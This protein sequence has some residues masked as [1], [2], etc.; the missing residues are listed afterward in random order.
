MKKIILAALT[1]SIA[2]VAV[3][4]VAGGNDEYAICLKKYERYVKTGKPLDPWCW[5]VLFPAP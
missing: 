3:P 4:A 2:A 1:L 5:D